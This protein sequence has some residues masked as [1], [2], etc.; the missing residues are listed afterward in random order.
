MVVAPHLHD[1]VEELCG[2][3]PSPQTDSAQLPTS[4]NHP[5]ED[6]HQPPQT[7]LLQPPG[8]V[9]MCVGRSVGP[10]VSVCV[11]ALLCSALY[12]DSLRPTKGCEPVTEAEATKNN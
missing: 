10:S 9:C 1:A 12:M 6:Q 3:G 5:V 4:A 8:Y 2:K 7:I 11:S